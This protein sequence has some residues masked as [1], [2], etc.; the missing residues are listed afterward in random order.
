MP[1][2]AMARVNIQRNNTSI[3]FRMIRGFFCSCFGFDFFLMSVF[4]CVFVGF[5]VGCCFDT[6]FCAFI[7]LVSLNCVKISRFVD[8]CCVCE[9]STS[10]RF[11]DFPLY[12]YKR[13]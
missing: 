12:F 4:F 13:G 9:M 5:F 8:F 2:V 11:R 3:V 10:N 6:F 1:S 7:C